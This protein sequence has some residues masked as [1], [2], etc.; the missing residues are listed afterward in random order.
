MNAFDRFNDEQLPS[1]E[2]FYSRLSEEDVTNGDYK[3]AKQIWKHFD[4]KNMGEYHD[5]FLKKD[6]VLLTDVF[7]NLKDMCLSFN[8]LDPVYC[9]LPNFAFDAMPKLAGIEIDL[10]Y[11]QDMYEMIEAGLRGGMTQTTCKKVEANN[12][13]GNDNDKNKASSYINDLD[14]NNLYG[15]ST[16]HKLPY[17]NQKWDGKITEE[18]IIDYDHGRTGYT[19]SAQTSRGRKFQRKRIISQRKNLPIECAEGDRPARCPNHFFAV[20]EP[21]AVPWR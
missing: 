17:R 11:D 4:F 21:S 18:D 7:E 2:Q 13:L 9:T 15:L 16:I 10:V 8:G 6:V 5:L 20:N 19:T 14:A 12:K 3:E 1:K